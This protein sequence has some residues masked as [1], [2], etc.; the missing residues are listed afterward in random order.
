MKT[1]AFIKKHVSVDETLEFH[2]SLC[3]KYSLLSL[4]NTRTH[5]VCC[6][7]WTPYMHMQA[8]GC[9][10]GPLDQCLLSDCHAIMP[11]QCLPREEAH[12]MLLLHHFSKGAPIEVE[13][14][15]LAES[16]AAT[17]AAGGVLEP[18]REATFCFPN[19]RTCMRLSYHKLCLGRYTSADSMY[20]HCSTQS[21]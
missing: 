21:E 2:V 19:S 16:S 8:R 13:I 6:C 1:S 18:C 5:G 14:L 3:Q 9:L 4:G 17:C 20:R 11:S 7:S 10:K 12:S 15:A